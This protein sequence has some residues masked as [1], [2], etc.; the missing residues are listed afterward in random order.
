MPFLIDLLGWRLI[1][2]WLYFWNCQSGMFA[3]TLCLFHLSLRIEL[4]LS[5]EKSEFSNQLKM[6][7]C[8][9]PL[10]IQLPSVSFENTFHSIVYILLNFYVIWL[11]FMSWP[12]VLTSKFWTHFFFYI[13]WMC[14]KN[15]YIY[16][17]SVFIS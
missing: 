11:F 17:I 8:K 9:K 16:L 6:M 3:F 2:D 10:T 15:I 4:M 5:R 7:I 12:I 1:K 13:S 14:I